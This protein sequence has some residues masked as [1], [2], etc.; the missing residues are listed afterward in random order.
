MQISGNSSISHIRSLKAKEN[1]TKMK[2]ETFYTAQHNIWPEIRY[3]ANYISTRT[4]LL[5]D[6]CKTVSGSGGN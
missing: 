4:S 1:I 3:S 2:S 6:V 5:A